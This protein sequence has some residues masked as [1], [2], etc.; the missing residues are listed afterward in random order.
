M[1]QCQALSRGNEDIEEVGMLTEG[2][3]HGLS[4]ERPLM[5]AKL[6]ILAGLLFGLREGIA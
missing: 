6:L 2:K 1:N 5:S 3:S 4:L